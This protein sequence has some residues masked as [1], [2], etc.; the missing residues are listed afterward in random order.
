MF[1]K[2]DLPE[3]L[4]SSEGGVAMRTLVQLVFSL[5]PRV[6]LDIRHVHLNVHQDLLNVLSGFV[7]ALQN[8]GVNDGYFY[9]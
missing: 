5:A 3:V 4:T 2:E 8:G 6:R 9:G 7:L 1:Q